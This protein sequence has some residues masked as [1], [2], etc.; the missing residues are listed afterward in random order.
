MRT[1]KHY[2][3]MMSENPHADF[4][5]TLAADAVYAAQHGSICRATARCTEE[6]REIALGLK[7]NYG[8]ILTVTEI[9]AE[10]ATIRQKGGKK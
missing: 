6:W 5:Y 7:N 3:N 2:E 1:K 4:S 9:R 8:D 10:M